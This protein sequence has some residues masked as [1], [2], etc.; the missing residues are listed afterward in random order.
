MRRTTKLILGAYLFTGLAGGTAAWAADDAQARGKPM[1]ADASTSQAPLISME[2]AAKRARA[3]Y[4]GE[5]TEAEL[6]REDG[7]RVWEVKVRDRDQ[8]MHKVYLDART[9]KALEG[10]KDD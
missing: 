9:G 1:R 7:R 3:Q 4:N 6:D 2:E 5:V 8:K 10:E